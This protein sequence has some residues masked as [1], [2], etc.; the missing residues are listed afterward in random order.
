MK[1]ETHY[2]YHTLLVIATIVG[3]VLLNGVF[4]IVVPFLFS[5]LP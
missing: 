4:Q 1:K 5:L 2:I 3:I